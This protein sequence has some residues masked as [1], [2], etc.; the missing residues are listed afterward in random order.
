MLVDPNIQLYLNST[1]LD[2]KESEGFPKILDDSIRDRR[3]KEQ[4]PV[5][6]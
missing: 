4:E 6:L 5:F 1:N 2:L 3:K